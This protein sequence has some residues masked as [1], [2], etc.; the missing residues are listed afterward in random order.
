[1][2]RL[3]I[4]GCFGYFSMGITMLVLLCLMAGCSSISDIKTTRSS[5]E[6]SSTGTL[7][8]TAKLSES[9][10]THVV[11]LERVESNGGVT[12]VERI[13]ADTNES[14]VLSFNFPRVENCNNANFYVLTV[15]D[16]AGN[17]QRRSLTAAPPPGEN[18]LVGINRLSTAQTN[19]T[20]EGFI[21][22]GTD[23][24]FFAG[25]V[26]VLQRSPDIPE[27]N[28]PELAQGVKDVVL[29][30]DGV[31]DQVFEDLERSMMDQFDKAMLCND[32]A[33]E[34]DFSDYT[35]L[36]NKANGKASSE[37]ANVVWQQGSGK[38]AD[39]FV[40]AAEKVGMDAT[41]ILGAM[42]SA[43]RLTS[44]N[45]FIQKLPLKERLVTKLSI[46]TF[47][48]RLAFSNWINN[49]QSGI[50][51]L[52]GSN[53][54]RERFL[55][56]SNDIEESL[57][58]IYNEN[59]MQFITP[60][61]ESFTTILADMNAA[62]NGVY[63]DFIED[64]ESKK[65]DVANI[66]QAL[67]DA[68]E[69]PS[70]ILESIYGDTFGLYYHASMNEEISSRD[71]QTW[72]RMTL[73]MSVATM[74]IADLIKNGGSLKYTPDNAKVP[75]NASWLNAGE[76]RREFKDLADTAAAEIVVAF[77][78][79]KDDV[80]ILSHRR[81]IQVIEAKMEE[82]SLAVSVAQHQ[83][84]ESLQDVRANLSGTLSAGLS[85]SDKHKKAL[86]SLLTYPV[87]E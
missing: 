42:N 38:M 13:N 71:M 21:G 69:A 63:S 35:T 32:K 36:M 44:E 14:G 24:A 50:V 4:K 47:G 17:I 87:F 60:N 43:A 7:S 10:Q 76:G 75:Q 58:I 62:F 33:D 85:L 26:T 23:S 28:M 1:M 22:A 53:E 57:R 61:E 74:Y 18:V 67:S 40:D 84:V 83:F 49:Y 68:I 82:D 70:N 59:A 45:A 30:S 37:D 64:I 77:E 55:S 72:P 78:Q 9:N 16:A 11:A 80:A 41:L 39:I 20:L 27:E 54:L 46:E 52:G 48:N 19:T 29:G 79:L 5:R 86:V 6:S 2:I 3:G 65:G 25:M 12:E 56:I 81:L 8:G 31:S 51:V 66:K 15:Y 34:M 73:P